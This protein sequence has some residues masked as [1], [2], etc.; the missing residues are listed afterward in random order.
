MTRFDEATLDEL[1]FMERSLDALHGLDLVVLYD[2]AVE[3]RYTFSSAA[4]V[5]HMEKKLLERK[6]RP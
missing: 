6:L 5:R 2:W 3:E 1:E 4:W